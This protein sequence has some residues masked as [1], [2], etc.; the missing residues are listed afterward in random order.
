MKAHKPMDLSILLG[1]PLNLRILIIPT[2]QSRNMMCKPSFVRGVLCI[3]NDGTVVV[4]Q[5]KGSRLNFLANFL[6]G[7]IASYPWSTPD[8]MQTPDVNSGQGMIY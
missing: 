7:E 1:V 5:Q 3:L 6:L 4:R 2:A 8:A